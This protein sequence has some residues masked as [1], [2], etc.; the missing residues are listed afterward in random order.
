MAD[1]PVT[2]PVTEVLGF[3][4]AVVAMLNTHKTEPVSVLNGA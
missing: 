2:F 3:C 4:D 1:K